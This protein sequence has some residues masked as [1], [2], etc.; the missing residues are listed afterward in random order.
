MKALLILASFALLAFAQYSEV[1]YDEGLCADCDSYSLYGLSGDDE[2]A[3]ACNW[4]FDFGKCDWGRPEVECRPAPPPPPP[5]PRR[6]KLIEK[7]C[8][9][10]DLEKCAR[11]RDM[12]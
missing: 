5:R 4:D 1:E 10:E 6:P 7:E 2:C 9:A 12:V 11:S 3:D 8:E